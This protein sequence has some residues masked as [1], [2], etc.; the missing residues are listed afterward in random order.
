M[1]KLHSI[2][3]EPSRTNGIQPLV[4]LLYDPCYQCHQMKTIPIFQCLL[5]VM[6]AL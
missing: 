3:L 1:K 5:S 6:R 4:N 2:F